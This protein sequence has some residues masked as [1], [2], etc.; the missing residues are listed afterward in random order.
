ML[1]ILACNLLE[2]TP[3]ESAV[4]NWVGNVIRPFYDSYPGI[5]RTDGVIIGA[6]S[7]RDWPSDANGALISHL[8]P[9][10][11]DLSFSS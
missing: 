11:I 5:G 6:G 7:I 3:C 8:F 10:D 9:P 4:G 2:L 1:L